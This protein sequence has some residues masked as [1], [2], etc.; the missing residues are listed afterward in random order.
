MSFIVAI[1]FTASNGDP[2]MRDSLHYVDPSR[3]TPNEY[4]NAILGVGQV[5]EFYDN[6]KVTVNF[7]VK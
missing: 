5:I 3:Q 7:C 4:V 6:E 2:H 1:D